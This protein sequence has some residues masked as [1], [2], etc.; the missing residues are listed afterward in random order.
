[1]T[2]G[3]KIV[4]LRKQKGMS[5][6]QLAELLGV[7][8]Q[9]VS[10]WERDEAF[11]DTEKVLSLSRIFGVSCDYLLKEDAPAHP[12]SGGSDV[13]HRASCWCKLHWYWAGLVLAAW[14]VINLLQRGMGYLAIR[15]VSDLSTPFF[16]GEYTAASP[17]D[18]GAF[19]SGDLS[20]WT[21]DL[22]S[23]DAGLQSAMVSRVML[24]GA[25][26][27]LTKIGAGLFFFFWGRKRVLHSKTAACPSDPD[28]Q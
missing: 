19:F 9:S 15:S 16:D 4:S 20:D 24:L 1:M 23:G 17:W 28:I 11:A 21:W 27:G 13:L 5:Q 14:G 12:L 3:E 7:S 2:F 10:K 25:L 8:L 6:D 18:S 22:S 26:N